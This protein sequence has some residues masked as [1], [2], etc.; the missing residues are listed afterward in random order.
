M[1]VASVSIKKCGSCWSFS[2]TE[3]IESHVF[4]ATGRL[5]ELSPQNMLECTPNPHHCGGTGGCEGATHELGFA[6]AQGGIAL[7]STVPYLAKDAPC[8]ATV[9]KAA[10]VANFVKLP[11]NDGQALLAALATVGPIS[12][13]VD[14]SEWGLYGGG[15]FNGCNATSPDLDHGVQVRS[16]FAAFASAE[17]LLISMLP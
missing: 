12:V 15:I 13:T 16:L 7:A 9:P 1:Y 17:V 8:N 4:L 3:S 2:A 10:H 11:T 6:W 14:A 5:L